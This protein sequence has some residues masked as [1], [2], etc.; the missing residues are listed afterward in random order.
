MCGLLVILLMD[1]ETIRVWHAETGS[2]VIKPLDMHTG[3]VY[4][5]AFSSNEHHIS[6]SNGRP[7]EFGVSMLALWLEGCMRL[8]IC[9][10]TCFALLNN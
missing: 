10:R 9:S 5:I 2:V 6:G 7:S 3:N 1:S 8:D 4:T